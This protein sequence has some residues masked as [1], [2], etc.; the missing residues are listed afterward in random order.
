MVSLAA[1]V[2]KNIGKKLERGEIDRIE[3]ESGDLKML[4]TRD[5]EEYDE[6]R[7]NKDGMSIRINGE[8]VYGCVYYK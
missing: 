5:R 6:H 1:W 3:V 7:R 2:E 4:C 8:F